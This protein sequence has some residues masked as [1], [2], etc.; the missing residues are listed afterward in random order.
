[1]RELASITDK[2]RKL[3]AECWLPYIP[4]GDMTPR[5]MQTL[6]DAMWECSAPFASYVLNRVAAWLDGDTPFAGDDVFEVAWDD[7]G[8]ASPSVFANKGRNPAQKRVCTLSR[9]NDGAT[10][11]VTWM[12]GKYRDVPEIALSRI[13][14]AGEKLDIVRGEITTGEPGS[15]NRHRF[16]NCPP[17]VKGTVEGDI[18]Y[19]AFDDLC[20]FCAAIR[21]SIPDNLLEV[22][23]K[24]AVTFAHLARLQDLEP[25]LELDGGLPGRLGAV[26]HAMVVR[27]VNTVAGKWMRGQYAPLIAGLRERGAEWGK[28]VMSYNDSDYHCCVVGFADGS[29]GL[30]SDN[31]ASCADQHAYVAR[32]EMDG[33]GVKSVGVHVFHGDDNDY[34]VKIAAIGEGS[35]RPDFVYE[36]ESRTPSFPGG[37]DGWYGMTMFLWQSMADSTY[38]LEDGILKTDCWYWQDA[39]SE[40]T[41]VLKG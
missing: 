12:P 18:E 26:R 22:E 35:A 6:A 15:G 10:W 3:I 9:K 27:M 30:F 36:Y 4:Q 7:T 31:A 24:D 19:G 38:A 20:G 17:P 16:S 14:H 11:L 32:L 40:E 39:D 41:A 37:R 29:I 28:G 21:G 33:D 23:K 5:V 25:I 2:E 1:M 34:R 8:K 13:D